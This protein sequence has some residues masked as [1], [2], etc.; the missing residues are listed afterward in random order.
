MD[1]DGTRATGNTPHSCSSDEH[2]SDCKCSES[3]VVDDIEPR[4][5]AS[6]ISSSSKVS[7]ETVKLLQEQEEIDRMSFEATMREE[8]LREKEEMQ[9]EKENI[10]RIR[11]EAEQ[12]QRRLE[13]MSNGSQGGRSVLSQPS[14]VRSR[15]GENT[16]PKVKPRFKFD[17]KHASTPDDRLVRSHTNPFLPNA[18]ATAFVPRDTADAHTPPAVSGTI[19]QDVSTQLIQ[20]ACQSMRETSI[21]QTLPPTTIPKF[22][23]K[24][25]E[26]KRFID[27]FTYGICSKTTD[28][29]ERLNYLDQYLYGDAKNLIASCRLNSDPN[30]GY[31]Q[32]VELLERKYGSN[33]D[34]CNAYLDKIRKFPKIKDK[35]D[36][37]ALSEFVIHVRE[38]EAAMIRQGTLDQMQAPAHMALLGS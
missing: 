24:I 36:D 12:R 5:S 26:Y 3:T 19:T 27:A 32:A 28:S 16:D 20:L 15:N 10:R 34:L 1:P 18:T 37:K 25:T 21:R 11:F 7:Q 2:P 22:D 9:K 6:Q 35:N 23:G 33:F 14:S 8:Q 30:I 31:Q 29:A 13:V 17:P 4:D 38:C